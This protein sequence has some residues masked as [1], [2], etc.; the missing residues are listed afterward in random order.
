MAADAPKCG[1]DDADALEM[2]K[3]NRRF[4]LNERPT[5]SVACRRELSASTDWPARIQSKPRAFNATAATLFDA[6]CTSAV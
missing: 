1:D 6:I 4:L 2:I 3:I 5:N